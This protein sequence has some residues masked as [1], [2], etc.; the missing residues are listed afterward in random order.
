LGKIVYTGGT[1]DIIH[2][3]HVKFLEQCRKIAGED[4]KVVVALNTDEF[5]KAYKGKPPVMNYL[6]RKQVLLG[7][8]AVDQVVPNRSGADSKPTILDVSPDFVV[9]GSDWAKKDYYAQMGFNQAWLDNLQIT[10][11]YVPY[12]EGISTTD[13]KKR[14]LML[15]KLETT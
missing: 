14:V 10:L 13:L 11:L 1:F 8:R 2:S 7:L 15:D 3:G 9:I 5:I 12:T 6:E 4:G